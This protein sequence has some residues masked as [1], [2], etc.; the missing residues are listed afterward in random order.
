MF[1]K[2]SERGFAFVMHEAFESQQPTRL[3]SESSHIGDYPDSAARPGSSGLWVG[4]DHRLDRQQ[5]QELVD[6]MQHWLATGRL[7]VDTSAKISH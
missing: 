1:S 5:V 3:I 6:R 7:A 2:M 4:N